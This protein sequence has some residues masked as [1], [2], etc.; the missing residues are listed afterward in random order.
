MARHDVDLVALD[1][2]AEGDLGLPEDHPY[3]QGGRHPLS[4]VRIEVEFL[5]DLLVEEVQAIEVQHQD[6]DPERPVMPGEDRI[7][8]VIE[9]AG[10]G[11]ALVPLPLRFGLIPA[12][13]DDRVRVAV[14]AAGA[15]W[16]A[17]LAD[18]L[19]A[20]GVVNDPQDVHEHGGCSDE[21]PGRDG[22]PPRA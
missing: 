7:G 17:E 8:Q 6:P 11:P 1:L 5:G 14:R 10:A 3:P 19:V 21:L 9:A 13:L 18:H 2:A 15:A 20:L 16:Q 4:V 12:L 22:W